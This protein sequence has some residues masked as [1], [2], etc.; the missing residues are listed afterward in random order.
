VQC[1]AAS[2]VAE[3]DAQPEGGERRRL[4]GEVG[5]R[6]A[7]GVAALLQ[8][9]GADIERRPA[10][11][12]AQ[13]GQQRVTEQCGQGGQHEGRRIARDLRRR[14]GE[15]SFREPL[16]LVLGQ[17]RGGE[18][19]AVEQ[20]G[21]ARLGQPALQAQHA[22]EDRA[23]GLP[24]HDPGGGGPAPQAVIDEAR[25]RRA[26]AGAGEAVGEA[27]ILQGIGGRAAARGDVVQ[28]LDGGGEA[29]GGGQDRLRKRFVKLA[30][31]RPRSDQRSDTIRPSFRLFGRPERHDGPVRQG[32]VRKG[33]PGCHP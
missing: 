32:H 13:L 3:G 22:D 11:E 26:V 33:P 16:P 18:A 12:R 29:G 1:R 17:G 27:P 6:L 23:A 4:G 31:V 24:A 8:G 9:V 7:C 10:P 2:V 21:D 14:V 15:A 30:T 5:K 20:R 19:R 25:D 28:D